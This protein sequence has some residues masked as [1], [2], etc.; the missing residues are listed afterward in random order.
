MSFKQQHV[1]HT[2]ASLLTIDEAAQRMNV[3]PST[4]QEMIKSNQLP[5]IHVGGEKRVDVSQVDLY[6]STEKRIAAALGSNET[7]EEII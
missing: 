4:V 6:T 1:E 7:V 3:R 5:V 2:P